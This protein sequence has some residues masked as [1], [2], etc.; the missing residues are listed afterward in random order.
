ML[1]NCWSNSPRCRCSGYP[2]LDGVGRD[3][4]RS[5]AD[6]RHGRAPDQPP[7]RQP[8][9]PEVG[10]RA[11]IGNRWANRHTGTVESLYERGTFVHV[12]I[13]PTQIGRVFNPDTASSPMPRP[14]SNS[15]SMSPANKA[16]GRIKD[17]GAWARGLRASQEAHAA[18][19]PLRR[20][21]LKPQR[22]YQEMN[23]ALG[24]RYLLCQHDRP[25]AD[26]RR[27]IPPRL[28]TAQLDQ[29]RPGRPA[30]LDAAGGTWGARRLS[31]PQ[32]RG[33]VRA[34]TISNS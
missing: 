15:S 12:D 11:R 29:L 24:S 8:D 16:A 20:V 21:P 18:P 22:V 17:R 1:R 5:S 31:R 34:T 2:D 7:V 25:V 9:I 33:A 10:F 23:E 19:D 26:R 30:G 27:P 32:D 28:Q 14:P 6:G 3:S 4:R 13:E